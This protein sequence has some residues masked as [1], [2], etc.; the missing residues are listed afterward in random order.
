[1]SERGRRLRSFAPTNVRE[2]FV[3]RYRLVYRVTSHRVEIIAFA[4]TARD[5][6]RMFGG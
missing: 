3:Q 2:V 6:D 4:H 1:M 5:F